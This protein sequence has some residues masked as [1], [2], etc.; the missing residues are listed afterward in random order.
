M[1]DV[2]KHA[3]D[4]AFVYLFARCGWGNKVTFECRECGQTTSEVLK[5][6][7]PYRNWSTTNYNDPSDNVGGPRRPEIQAMVDAGRWK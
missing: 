4:L 2:C 7:S 1:T 5:P 3:K 6:D